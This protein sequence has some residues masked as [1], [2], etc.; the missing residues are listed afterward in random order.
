[1]MNGVCLRRNLID[2]RMYRFLHKLIMS[3]QTSELQKEK[4][5]LDQLQQRPTFGIVISGDDETNNDA[6]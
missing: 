4:A 5:K 2:D 3:T 6:K 1:M